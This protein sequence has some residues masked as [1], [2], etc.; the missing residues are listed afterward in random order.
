MMKDYY[1]GLRLG[2]REDVLNKAFK[3]RGANKELRAIQNGEFTPFK[4]SD[5]VRKAFRENAEAIGE[6]DPYEQ[7]RDYI[8]EIFGFYR[9]LPLSMETLPFIPNPFREVQLSPNDTTYLPSS[10]VDDIVTT[11]GSTISVA[12]KDGLGKTKGY[13]IDNQDNI[14][15]RKT[16]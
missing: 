10:N 3:T 9:G 1:A 13:E 4:V 15:P 2:G 5:N 14:V 6:A 8:N 12:N 11:A 16:V 7:V